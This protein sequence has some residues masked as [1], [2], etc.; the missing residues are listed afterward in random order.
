MSV[1]NDQINQIIA[2]SPIWCAN[3]LQSIH[4]G[5]F[6]CSSSFFHISPFTLPSFSLPNVLGLREVRP[7]EPMIYRRIYLQCS[8][9]GFCCK[10][11]SLLMVSSIPPEICLPVGKYRE[12]RGLDAQ[13]RASQFSKCCFIALLVSPPS[14]EVAIILH[15]YKLCLLMTFPRQRSNKF[16][17]HPGTQVPCSWML[18][19]WAGMY[20]QE[21]NAKGVILTPL[22][23]E[24]RRG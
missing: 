19:D 20:Y 14:P 7:P 3:K 21:S 6:I 5:F 12:Q 16:K 13:K 18:W 22:R 4:W 9:P 2:E 8:N 17:R 15:A 23:V 11:Y 24:Y 1:Y 10:Q